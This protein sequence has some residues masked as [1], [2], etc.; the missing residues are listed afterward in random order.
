MSPPLTPTTADRAARPAPLTYRLLARSLDAVVVAFALALLYVEVT[1]RW[2]DGAPTNLVD[3]GDSSGLNLRLTFLAVTA[4]YELLPTALAGRTFGKL[5]LGLQVQRAGAAEAP[6][7]G[8]A[9]GRWIVLIG[10][11]ALP[12][13]GLPALVVVTGVALFDPRRR[14]LHDRLAGTVVMDVGIGRAAN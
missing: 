14:G 9:A 13:V 1:S 4:L 7:F 8:R 6:G 2:S 10:A 5:L 12:V 3:A 11:A